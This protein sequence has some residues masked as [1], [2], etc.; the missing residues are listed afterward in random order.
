VV[1]ALER[2]ADFEIGDR[3][4]GAQQSHGH[5]RSG[6]PGARARGP[7]RVTDRGER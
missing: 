6:P 1:R 4:P 5:R 7:I 2:M 3:P